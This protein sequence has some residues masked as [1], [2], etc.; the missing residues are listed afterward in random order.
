MPNSPSDIMLKNY[1]KHQEE[2]LLNNVEMCCSSCHRITQENVLYAKI[3]VCRNCFVTRLGIEVTPVLVAAKLMLSNDS[4]DD[5]HLA[6]FIIRLYFSYTTSGAYQYTDYCWY[7][8][9]YIISRNE[10]NVSG[11]MN[12]YY[13]EGNNHFIF[14]RSF[15]SFGEAECFC[16]NK[17]VFPVNCGDFFFL[18][19]NKSNPLILNK[20]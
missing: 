16:E 12:V 14:F 2:N 1:Y 15:S 11:M 5:F 3:H 20:Y 9:G 6:N 19:K 7:S 10:F 13:K 4:K 8:F 17:K 18:L